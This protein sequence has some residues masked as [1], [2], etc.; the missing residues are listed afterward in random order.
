MIRIIPFLGHLMNTIAAQ[1]T[2]QTPEQIDAATVQRTLPC[3]TCGYILKGQRLD[4]HCS[5]CGSPVAESLRGDRLIFHRPAYLNRLRIGAFLV[6]LG[7]VLT[8][9]LI[10]WLGVL[11]G[12]LMLLVDRDHDTQEK[13][14]SRRVAGVLL[15]IAALGIA[16]WI[17]LLVSGSMTRGSGYQLLLVLG[18]VWPLALYGH[19]SAMTWYAAHLGQRGNASLIK[20]SAIIFTG[21]ASLA[22]LIS[23]TSTVATQVLLA[24]GSGPGLW[25]TVVSIVSSVFPL[26][27]FLLYAL[28][29][30]HLT[31]DL[32]KQYKR[33]KELR[34][35]A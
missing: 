24:S 8:I 35:M 9:V 7:T 23:L 28:V 31:L 15:G 29:M 1:P 19:M 22:C 27:L 32:H 33:A 25:F 2:P 30:G 18:G 16:V 6:C 11:I 34:G 12:S 5:E 13:L 4:G 21:A 10:G 17:G 3:H 20:Q 26:I 14:A